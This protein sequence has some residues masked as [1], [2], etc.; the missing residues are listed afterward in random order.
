MTPWVPSRM[1]ST[2]RTLQEYSVRKLRP[3]TD[4]N[5]LFGAEEVTVQTFGVKGLDTVRALQ[6][7]RFPTEMFGRSLKPRQYEDLVREHCPELSGK[8]VVQSTRKL[9]RQMPS[10]RGMF[11]L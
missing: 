2:S 3:L 1:Y 11:L 7:T 9:V 8:L 4:T 10:S 5:L 6:H